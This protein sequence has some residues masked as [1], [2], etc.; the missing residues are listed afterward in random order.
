MNAY[1]PACWILIPDEDS[2]RCEGCGN[3]ELSGGGWPR[4]GLL[5]EVVDGNKYEVRR[6]LGTG[7]FGRVYEVTH[8]LIGRRLAMKVLKPE[9]TGNP[10][11]ERG[12]MQEVAALMEIQHENLVSFHDVGRLDNGRL[13]L[14]MELVDGKS[15]WHQV[16]A[17]HRLLTPARAVEVCTQILAALNAAHRCKVL[18]RDLKPDNVLIDADGRVRVI[19]FGI[20]KVLGP[21]SSAQEI[22]RVVGTPRW[23]APEQFEPGRAVDARLDLYALGALCHF[24][25]TGHPPYR[26]LETDNTVAALMAIA[27]QQQK[28]RRSAGPAPS[29]LRPQ[30]REVAPSLDALV[31]KLLS[32]DPD[33]R[34]DSAYEVQQLLDAAGGEVR[35]IVAREVGG[36]AKPRGAAS[37]GRPSPK[38]A[39]APKAPAPI[40]ATGK[41]K[42]LPRAVALAAGIA[43]V[44][45]LA[46]LAAQPWGSPADAPAKPDAV[47]DFASLQFDAPPFRAIAPDRAAAS[48]L[49]H[50]AVTHDGA[51]AVVA[52]A[53]G[54]VFLWDLAAHKSAGTLPM[55]GARQVAAAPD[56]RAV[57]L[58]VRGAL[59]IVH[60]DDESVSARRPYPRTLHPIALGPELLVAGAAQTELAI[61]A[62]DG[63]WRTVSGHSRDIVSIAIHPTGRW[64]ATGSRDNT[65]RVVE[66]TTGET[67]ATLTNFT[68]NMAAVAFSPDGTQLATGS[69]D[70]TVSWIDVATWKPTAQQVGHADAVTTLAWS[71]DSS[72][73]VSGGRN[74]TVMLW[75]RTG[76]AVATVSPSSDPIL[77]VGWTQA[78]QLVAASDTILE[79]AA[80]GKPWRRTWLRG[81][82]WASL[83]HTGRFDCTGEGCALLEYEL[84]DGS[85]VNTETFAVGRLRGV[86]VRGAAAAPRQGT[87][88]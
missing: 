66:A 2:P 75:T 41:S 24:L 74:G 15:L 67:V 21:N 84:V 19:D 50:M 11:Y 44:A 4:D 25:L 54:P 78:G 51:T 23:M 8:T 65:V 57:A 87:S 46:W 82:D 62:A 77:G 43:V 10:E 80:V 31:A 29:L 64:I 76:S 63:R 79:M 27:S 52:L 61:S 33:R 58:F 88:P 34:P 30:L 45:G 38:A 83:A 16:S 48:L 35:R 39:R 68:D 5:G 37:V 12:F 18:H 32:T 17:P 56:Q 55:S 60:L 7:G 28:R 70:Q 86:D 47:V 22:S 69:W 49:R 85:R 3:V 1:C 20:S 14:L 42:I 36:G 71:S 72:H 6:I 59:E 40:Q 53:H 26:P 81:T 9:V 13:F 73:L